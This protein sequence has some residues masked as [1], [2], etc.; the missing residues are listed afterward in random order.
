MA[1]AIGTLT[2]SKV[3]T[4]IQLALSAGL[5]G[6]TGTGSYTIYRDTVPNITPG[7]SPVLA[8]VSS[9][10]FVDTS[11]IPRVRYYYGISG[12]D[13]SG[14]VVYAAPP[15]LGNWTPPFLCGV[16]G[17]I[18]DITSCW[19][20]DSET[21]GVGL[22]I[23]AGTTQIPTVPGYAQAWL[24]ATTG[25]TMN[26]TNQG[27]P[28]Y[29]SVDFLPTYDGSGNLNYGA[30]AGAM[31]TFLQPLMAANPLSI[32]VFSIQLG[33]NDAAS[34]G[35]TNGNLTPAQ[36]AANMR[37][38]S[39]CFLQYG[40]ANCVV[41]ID[42]PAFFSPNT[43]NTAVYLQA[44]AG[45]VYAY[46]DAIAA[47]VAQMAVAYPGRIYLGDTLQFDYFSR[48]YLAEMQPDNSG[49][50]G[51]FYLHYSGTVGSN[52]RIGTQT[53]GEFRA[54]ALYNN[55]FGLQTPASAGQSYSFA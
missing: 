36:Y 19:A 18:L 32:P 39:L 40:P 47:M 13:S 2:T 31:I 37:A 28:G 34:S 11:A 48:N 30:G 6:V 50:N 45:V 14:S 42:L 55:L 17:A 12:T 10:S 46:R 27:R 49:P 5:T 3:A 1:L 9:P 8:T 54:R 22:G 33:T 7:S 15:D 20:G 53:V 52:G 21:N 44:A 38:I 16:A 41:N 29:S 25:A 23:Y 4:G 26:G 43:Q 51:T 24:A 35:S